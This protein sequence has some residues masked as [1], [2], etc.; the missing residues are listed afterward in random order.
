M[1]KHKWRKKVKKRRIIGIILLF[2]E[3][4]FCP[5]VS[6]EETSET[7][8]HIQTQEDLRKLAENC[9]LD[10][11]SQ[12]KTVFLD[13][14]IELDGDSSEFLPIPTFGG[15][16]EGNG[17]TVQNLS[18]QEESGRTGFFDTLQSSAVVR[19][20]NV[21]G[22]L[23]LNAE[24]DS[25]GGLAGINYGK[26]VE[27]S[28]HGTVEGTA[29]VGGL[30]GINETSGQIISSTFQGTVT[31]EHYVG[32]ISGQNTGNLVQCLNEGEVN[33]TVLDVSAD[34]MDI[35]SLQMAKNTPAG[36]D[37]GG[38]TGFS[39]G[40]VQNCRNTGNVG[41]PHIGYNVGGIA[42]RQSGY[43]EGCSN[44]GEVRGRKDVGGICGQQEPQVTLRYDEDLLEQIT[45]ELNT[46]SEMTDKAAE[47]VR[48]GSDVFSQNMSSLVSDVERAREAAKDLSDAVVQWGSNNA[49]DPQAEQLPEDA[50]DSMETARSS[51]EQSLQQSESAVGEPSQDGE[52]PLL[53][54][55]TNLTQ[56]GDALHAALS[57][58]V[59]TTSDL[60]NGI[61]NSS[62]TIAGDL[63][64]ISKQVQVIVALLQEHVEEKST[65]ESTDPF[66][67]VSDTTA[68]EAA[69]GR[70]HNSHN[71]GAINGDVNVAG[72]A[73]S[74]AI[75][76]DFDPEDDLTEEGDRSLN[77]RYKT[78]AV[79]SD[80][81]NEGEVSCKKN[82][83]GGIVGRMDLGAVKSCENY[84]TA[85][86]D[87]GDYIGGIAGFS[88]ASIRDSFVK[89]FL[90]GEDYLGGIVGSNDEN[91]LV[92]GCYAQV[93]I[94]ASGSCQGAV[95]GTEDG[96]FSENYY[97][98]DQIAGLGR[99][100]YKGQA[101]PIDFALLEQVNGMPDGMTHF[102]L[103]FR[104]EGEEVKKE[105]FSYGAT[106]AEDV[107]P[108]IPEKEGYYAQ[109][110]KT[111]LENLCFDT[112]V[113]AE[114][115]RYVLLLPS[116]QQRESGR[117]VFLME[118]AFKDGDSLT[119]T[120]EETPGMVNGK[121]A[122]ERW[123]LQCSDTMRDSY[124][125][126]YLSPEESADGYSVFIKDN[127]KWKALK[128][129]SFGSCLVFTVPSAECE[130]AVVSASDRWIKNL[131]IL[132]IIAVLLLTGVVRIWKHRG[133][134]KGKS[135]RKRSPKRKRQRKEFLCRKR[136]S[137][138]RHST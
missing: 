125:V 47:D 84:G 14:D 55:D 10:S 100:S 133:K 28:F 116:S 117:S 66:E 13:N 134:E 26:I 45:R 79:V 40:L 50:E 82:Y 41:Y 111:N 80:C 38:I 108:E 62:Q 113:T 6:G 3:L 51:M 42:G 23:S 129:T 54:V 34:L 120:G 71:S 20:L 30:V 25:V 11:W 60:Q 104:V 95:S 65:E 105:T 112:V 52:V 4:A 73:G 53:P 44:E 16:F 27:S 85:G 86:S 94:T 46:L 128:S 115:S 58:M 21:E 2:C 15:T 136:R 99:I 132:L 9:R 124:T 43:M 137:R 39:A 107:F 121:A 118:G 68:E 5:V 75:E 90:S 49:V 88:R 63:N 12:G 96:R 67:D 57:Q 29:S 36:T 64:A 91:G 59:D 127:G 109:W 74:L 126:R 69:A 83:A 138:I 81:V 24:S 87:N 18:L 119:V 131:V 56:K 101:E 122:V 98:S 31:G 33:T 37:I 76:F 1:S 72:I 61:V 97:V 110:D 48:S 77:F 22:T 89:C 123:K 8:I 92:S 32:G 17:H 7:A 70:I 35:S 114:Y 93:E 106:F 130:V 19:G 103:S 135:D 102:T 78:L